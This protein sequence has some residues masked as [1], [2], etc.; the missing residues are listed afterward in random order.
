[1]G[2]S[3]LVF[4]QDRQHAPLDL[5]RR[6]VYDDGLHGSV[7]RLQP[8][9]PV[10]FVI[11]ALERSFMA[12]H[13]S[14]D[15]LAVLRLLSAFHQHV[16]AAHN[17]ILNHRFAAHFERERVALAREVGE[18]QRVLSFDSFHGC[19][20]GY[21]SGERNVDRPCRR[22]AL[23]P[24]LNILRRNFER[25]TLIEKPAQIV[26]RFERLYVL[27]HGGEG[28]EMKPLRQFFVAGTIAVLFD[29]VR[30]EVEHFLLPLGQSH[31]YIVGRTK[32][33][34][35]RAPCFE[36]PK[37]AMIET[38]S[39]DN[40]L[41]FA[42]GDRIGDYE[43]LAPLGAGGMGSVYKVRHAISQRIEALKVIVPNA[44]A[45][46][47]MAERFLR[48]IRLQA[49]LEHPHIASLHNAFRKDDQLV[50][51][52]EFVEGV[53]LRDKI[54]SPGIT[55]AQ[56]LEYAAQ[57]LAALA[58]AH[59]HGVIH[60]EIKPSNVIIA[61]HGVVKLLDFGLAASLNPGTTPGRDDAELTQPGTMLG[62]PYYMSPEQ[63]LG[64]RA[65][66]RSDVYSTGAMLFE[67]V[68]GRP[69]FEAGGTGGA[70]AIIA[71]H[72]RTAPRPPSELNAQVPPELDR[73]I[74]KALAKN[75]A[76]RFSSAA[77]FL[78]AVEAVRLQSVRL[79]D[80]ITVAAQS[81][82]PTASPPA[83]AAGAEVSV[84]SAADLERVSKDLASYIG[85]IAQI[86]VRRAAAESHSLSELYQTLA[87]EISSSSKREQFLASMPRASLSRS[88]GGTPSAGSRTSG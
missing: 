81:L 10:R 54:H 18:L 4:P 75:P 66:A 48:E 88:T 32:G 45:V 34:V 25:T 49:S 30:D 77:A 17:V 39:L 40:K 7:G 23:S 74:L 58:Y 69:P 38:M 13:Q 59:A 60:R 50:M 44:S 70:Y 53:S 9:A 65:D 82:R 20:G 76:E 5:Y 11:K 12:V 6:R 47:E 15:D 56:A 71:G 85:P 14:N 78:A 37:L 43:V 79:N 63:A 73:I 72:L 29:E 16:V 36:P 33:E 46:P 62:S 28:G 83:P 8:D 27:V 87:Q 68:A 42:S 22:A 35:N 67:M 51:V 41:I 52:M 84:H 19:A 61:S 1:M 55:L 86:L 2:G 3:L 80:T 21:P 57:V 26:A 24:F 31:A 64:D